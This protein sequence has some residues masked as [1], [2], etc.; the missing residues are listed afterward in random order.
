MRIERSAPAAK[1]RGRRWA[2]ADPLAG[3][4]R[5]ALAIR[6]MVVI[7][8]GHSVTGR[9]HLIRVCGPNARRSRSAAPSS[10]CVKRTRTKEPLN[11]SAMR[12]GRAARRPWRASARCPAR[13]RRARDGGRWS[14]RRGSNP[15]HS[16][17]KADALPT[18]LLPHRVDET[19]AVERDRGVS[20]TA[21]LRLERGHRAA[22]LGAWPRDRADRGGN[23]T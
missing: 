4:R 14:G 17:W 20:P 21:R 16:A 7:T 2:A 6:R 18:E 1:A 19:I 11:V 13:R 10:V 3:S 12:G 5:A 8:S 15:R 23:A 9:N 22:C